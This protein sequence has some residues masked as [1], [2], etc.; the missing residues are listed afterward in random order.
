MKSMIKMVTIASLAFGLA[1]SVYANNMFPVNPNHPTPIHTSSKTFSIELPS[2]PTT[3]YQW[4]VISTS[5][6]IT[7]DRKFFVAPNEPCCGAP[8]IDQLDITL[9][10]KFEGSGQIVLRSARSWENN[11][12]AD[13]NDLHIV[14]C[15]TK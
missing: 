15:K 4:Q 9:T 11:D 12:A 8:G 14:I 7:I 1:A 5:P 6:G 3:G 10:S 13:A 2:N